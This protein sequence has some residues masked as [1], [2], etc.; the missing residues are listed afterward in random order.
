MSQRNSDGNGTPNSLDRLEPMTSAAR[1]RRA[2]SAA[3]IGAGSYEELDAATA[4]FVAERRDAKVP[5]EQV[6]LAM[7]RILAE[8]G[9]RPSHEPSDPVIVIE[10]HAAVYRDVIAA[11]IR[12]Y[13]RP[14]N[15]NGRAPD[16]IA[17]A[18]PRGT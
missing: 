2:I 6:L 8:A 17:T 4:D 16:A 13:F 5:P 18:T 1:M 15:A 7:K 14:A 10:R 11:S 12:H 9:L 3:S